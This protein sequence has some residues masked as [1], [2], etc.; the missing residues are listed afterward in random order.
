ML[1]YR[2]TQG[3]SG[4]VLIGEYSPLAEI[5]QVVTDVS[6]RSDSLHEHSSF[7]AL[8]S[9]VK[10]AFEGNHGII[11]PSVGYEEIGVRYGVEMSWPVLL[12]QARMLRAELAY[13]DHSKWH[14]AVAWMLEAV[15]EEALHDDFEE[16]AENII[17]RLAGLGRA[18]TPRSELFNEMGDK[19]NS[20]SPKKRKSNLSKLIYAYWYNEQDS[21]EFS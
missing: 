2:L 16:E 13:T 17:K 15:I 6:D 14:Q 3:H 5:H 10:H 19:Y 21:L 20:W 18:S 1:S 11:Q 4:P 7:Q 12:M 8:A 9:D